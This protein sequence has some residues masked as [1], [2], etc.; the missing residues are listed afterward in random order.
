M[1]EE[2]KYIL[3]TKTTVFCFI[4]LLMFNMF[5]LYNFVTREDV[6][7]KES[8]KQ[9]M[10][11]LELFYM[12]LTSYVEPTDSP[13]YKEVFE[14]LYKNNLA[15][16]NFHHQAYDQMD[17]DKTLKDYKKIILK[18]N[19]LDTLMEINLD[20]D[21]N[22]VYPYYQEKYSLEIENHKDFINEKAFGFDTKRL[23][24]LGGVAT[25]DIQYK[26]NCQKLDYYFKMLDQDMVE[27]TEKD[28]N[29]WSYL[30]YH[31]GDQSYAET[32]LVMIG[33]LYTIS[34]VMM[35]RKDHR[36]YLM[37]IQ[38][39]SLF[40]IVM[41]QVMMIALTYL[42]IV[43]MSLLIPVLLLGVQYGFDGLR[44]PVFI[45]K[46]GL[47]G[48]QLFDHGDVINYVGLSYLPTKENL[49]QTLEVSIPSE[50]QMTTFLNN[51]SLAV[52]L[53]TMKIITFITVTVSITFWLRKVPYIIMTGSVLVGYLFVSQLFY[54]HALSINPFSMENGFK[55]LGGGATITYLHAILILIATCLVLIVF[56]KI[57]S[58]KCSIE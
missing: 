54:P 36:L 26:A 49:G 39:T 12:G 38:P 17:E 3:K 56:N 34:C 4:I 57:I 33:M 14:I 45:Y 1:R 18:L 52:L 25:K 35:L 41:K 21:G 50:V 27:V 11:D 19:I 10:K 5:Q 20:A 43:V 28:I 16:A 42:L 47:T 31:L 55:I 37:C 48:F 32:V 53:L 22:T 7:T 23:S 2:M 46:D 29:P 13:K 40:R 51:M 15:L 6:V 44:Q 24:K 30:I 9:E 8:I 58:D